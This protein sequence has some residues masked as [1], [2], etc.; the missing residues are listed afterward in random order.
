MSKAALDV[1]GI[2]NAIVDIISHADDATIVR[3]QMSKATMALIN[4]E[5]SEQLRKL[6]GPSVQLSGGSAG[7]TIAGL[8]S[9]GAKV[10]YI[11]KIR[12]DALGDAFRHDIISMG[13]QYPTPPALDGPPTAH[14]VIFVTPDAQRTMNTY[15]GACVNLT[16][17]D[18]D[19]EMIEAATIVY[20]EGYLF[21]LPNA[22]NAFRAAAD[23]AHAAGRQ[24]ALTLSD[25]FCVQRHRRA[26]LDL[27]ENRID[28]LFANE[29]ELAV[30]FDTEVL[31]DAVAFIVPKV[32]FAAITRGSLGS[33]IIT[34]GRI[35]SIPSARATSVVDTT[36][37]G[38]LYASGV[39][40]GL[41]TGR[42]SEECGWLGSVAAAEVIS[43]F[44]GRPVI[45]LKDYLTSRSIDR[46]TGHGAPRANP[47]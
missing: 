34:G 5:R 11:G 18:L 43:H 45:P 47:A 46:D 24:V 1:T 23:M 13:V 20:L 19:R 10:G 40:F 39:M 31:D 30:L 32:R 6:M 26:F 42:S 25:S 28:I 8:A 36:G 4:L 2:G 12:G 35:I 9:L 15:L 27:I 33:I 44:G 14:C 38:D 3:L 21:D 41:A 37:A 16:V 29:A 7:N 17:H 22:Q